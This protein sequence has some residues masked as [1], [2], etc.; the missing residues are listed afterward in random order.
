[1]HALGEEALP[2][3]RVVLERNYCRRA[4]AVQV[5][6]LVLDGTLE[7]GR[8]L[9]EAVKARTDD[10]IAEPDQAEGRLAALSLMRA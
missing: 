1:M 7:P 4:Y 10:G 8:F 6:A 5:L 2:G 3:V 9:A